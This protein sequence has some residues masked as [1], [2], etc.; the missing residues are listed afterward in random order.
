MLA[1]ASRASGTERN[2]RK[3]EKAGM[4]RGVK[5]S[6]AEVP[7]EGASMT[8]GWK[9]PKWSQKSAFWITQPPKIWSNIL[10]KQRGRVLGSR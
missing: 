6:P 5:G 4:R 9:V 7:T 2:V 8:E 3:R 1:G 10:S